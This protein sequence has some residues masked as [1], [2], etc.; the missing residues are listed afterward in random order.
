MQWY[1]M[2]NIDTIYKKPSSNPTLNTDS[3]FSIWSERLRTRLLSWAFCSTSPFMSLKVNYCCYI[4]KETLKS[5]FHTRKR[6][7]EM[8]KLK[9]SRRGK[10]SNKHTRRSEMT[11]SASESEFNSII[12][13]PSRLSWSADPPRICISRHS[14]RRTVTY[15]VI[16]QQNIRFK[17]T[18]KIE[19]DVSISY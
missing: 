17:M 1:P 2:P 18:S 6:E 3:L 10:I 11:F 15:N 8:E 9:K 16:T 12:V 19:K 4:Q 14:F 13:P 7:M 5:S